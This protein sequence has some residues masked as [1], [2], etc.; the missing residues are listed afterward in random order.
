MPTMESITKGRKYRVCTDPES[1]RWER[2]S[3]WTA[4]S[5]VELE[6][7]TTL[8]EYVA[9]L[10][11]DDE[12]A[13]Y[14]AQ[15]ATNASN[16]ENADRAFKS[17]IAVVANDVVYLNTNILDT[18]VR[19]QDNKLITETIRDPTPSPDDD[20]EYGLLDNPIIID[21]KTVSSI[22][23]EIKLGDTLAQIIGKIKYTLSVLKERSPSTGGTTNYNEL[24]NKP[25]INNVTLQGNMTLTAL[26]D[27][28]AAV[29]EPDID[30]IIQ[31]AFGDPIVLCAADDTI[32]VT[33]K[34]KA[35]RANCDIEDIPDIY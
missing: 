33:S 7:G 5:D 4:A 30:I 28:D 13:V 14:V 15:N 34:D 10:Q 32:L 20:D 12:G 1:N 25:K 21:T 17:D 8:A 2:Y 3:Y 6:D 16:A 18:I 35:I 31:R 22:D 24:T 23:D 26:M 19:I 29:S 27:Q 11:A 9:K